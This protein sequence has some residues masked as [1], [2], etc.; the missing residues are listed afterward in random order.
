M[1]VVST[2]WQQVTCTDTNGKNTGWPKNNPAPK[3]EKYRLA[4]KE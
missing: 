1:L 2:K 3:D 4:F